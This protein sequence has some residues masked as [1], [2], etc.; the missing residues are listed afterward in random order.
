MTP[1]QKAIGIAAA[2]MTVAC[3]VQ[4]NAYRNDGSVLLLHPKDAELVACRRQADGIYQ[5]SVTGVAR[6]LAEDKR[7]LL[8][9]Q[10]A[11]PRSETPGWYLQRGINGITKIDPA[12][13]EFSAV[14]QIGNLEWPPH[15]GDTMN[16]AITV[17]EAALTGRLL[18]EAGVV[19][20]VNLPGETSEI[21]WKVRVSTRTQRSGELP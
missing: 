7:L 6:G 12:S 13:G 1:I 14:G 21:A 5:F 20:R 8:W 15:T 9:V 16:V 10:P 18:S 11:D 19:T 17:V 2:I 3:G 4:V